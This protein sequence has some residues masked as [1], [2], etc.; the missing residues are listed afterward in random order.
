MNVTNPRILHLRETVKAAQ[1]V[2]DMAVTLHEVWKPAANDT[3]LHQRL[4]KS[5]ATQAFNVVRVAL[6]RE[7]VLALMRLWDRDAR[8]IGMPSIM[9]ALNDGAVMDILV[10]D[11]ASRLRIDGVED[12]IR[13]TLLEKVGAA[14]AL[15]DAYSA[16]GEK[17]ESFDKLRA[18]RNQRLA[19]TQVKARLLSQADAIDDV[20]EA[21]YQDNARIISGL[22]SVVSATAYDPFETAEVY[23]VYAKHFWASVRG[24]R[25]TT[26][27]SSSI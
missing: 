2:F 5:Y 8:A 10:L 1:D 6:R 27:S 9:K 7:M 3:H 23:R 12:E 16:A 25:S 20:I 19:H 26:R 15:V 21:F 24:E 14:N 22:L 13:R 18:L 11:R 17:A 4:G